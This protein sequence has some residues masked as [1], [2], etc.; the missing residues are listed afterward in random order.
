MSE[1]RKGQRVRV[2][3]EGTITGT[4]RDGTE[5]AA[6]FV[7]TG[8]GDGHTG[9]RVYTGIAGSPH[10]TVKIERL[11]PREYPPQVGDIWAVK[12]DLD[13][14]V[15]W[16]AIREYGDQGGVVM[17]SEIPGMG[18]MGPDSFRHLNP[19]LVRRRGQ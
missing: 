11:E 5:V 17:V 14:V 1:F 16:F 3:I 13:P 8:A 12:S 4:N 9:H 15:E 19:V 2:T 7:S 6:I 10:G 18:N